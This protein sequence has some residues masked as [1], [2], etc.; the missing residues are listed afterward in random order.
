MGEPLL[1]GLIDY[2]ATAD[3]AVRALLRWRD[4]RRKARA[5]VDAIAAEALLHF[6]SL[7]EQSQVITLLTGEYDEPVRKSAPR[8][9]TSRAAAGRGSRRPAPRRGSGVGL[10]KG[11]SRRAIRIDQGRPEPARRRVRGQEPMRLA[12]HLVRLDWPLIALGLSLATSRRGHP[13]L[14]LALNS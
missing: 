12:V 4:A 10:D 14:K 7:H 9:R 8:A 1:T 5:D 2:L 11:A 6:E 13:P 3:R